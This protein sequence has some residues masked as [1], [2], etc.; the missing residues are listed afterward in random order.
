MEDEI[1]RLTLPTITKFNRSTPLLGGNRS[2]SLSALSSRLE[3]TDSTASSYTTRSNPHNTATNSVIKV[4][5]RARTTSGLHAGA[6]AQLK[7]SSSHLSSTSVQASHSRSSRLSKVKSSQL[8]NAASHLSSTSAQSSRSRSSRLLK[9]KSARLKNP[10]SHLSSTSAKASRS[11]SSRRSKVKSS[12]LD[13]LDFIQISELHSESNITHISQ[14][15]VESTNNDGDSAAL[16]SLPK[17]P[18]LGGSRRNTDSSSRNGS[19]LSVF[20]TGNLWQSNMTNFKNGK[21]ISLPREKEMTY[22]GGGWTRSTNKI[23]VPRKHSCVLL[24]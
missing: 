5:S 17:F 20:T 23:L 13:S 1:R 19:E 16:S 12:K 8:E 21:R 18:L 14:C 15:D 22:L 3:T 4:P 10:S 7:N 24:N 11:R 2:K 9:V 6:S